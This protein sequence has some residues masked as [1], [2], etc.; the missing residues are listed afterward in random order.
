M[1]NIT[2]QVVIPA[3]TINPN[4]IAGSQFEFANRRRVMS[5]VITAGAAGILANINSGG[6]VVAEQFSVPIKA[7]YPIIPD[8]MYYN[9][10]QEVG[11]RLS[12]PVQNTTA[13]PIT[14]FAQ[15][16]FTDLN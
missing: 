1:S 5:A 15:I 13:A 12:I 8:E 11:D 4:I 7:N 9:D 3:N 10:V 14:V 16:Q 6:D 2:A